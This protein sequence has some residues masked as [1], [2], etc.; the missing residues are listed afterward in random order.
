MDIEALKER[1]EAEVD[2]R[3]PELIDVSHRIHARPELLF[4]EHHAAA[5]LCDALEGAG[6][7]VERGICDLATA[8]SAR[9]GG[10]NGPTIAV[11]LEYD[12][13]PGIGHACGHNIIAAAGLGTG[14]AA[15]SVADEVGGRLLVLGTPAEEGGGGK[16]LMAD[17]GAFDHV[18]AAMMV[19]PAHF[20]L[21]E[22]SSLAISTHEITYRG[23]AAHAAAFPWEGRNAL[24]AAVLGYTAVAALR[25][26]IRPSERVHGVFTI[27]GDKP[28]IVPELAVAQWY[29][30]AATI[31]ALAPLEA[32]V[33]AALEA[34]AAAAGCTME[35]RSLAPTYADVRTNAPMAA[36]YTLNAARSGRTVLP[37]T[38]ETSV[39]A[40]TDMG[41]ISYRVPSI[42]PLIKVP[43]DDTLIHTAGFA[44]WAAAPEGDR[45]V[46]DG[47][48]A[49]ATTVLDL[50][51]RPECLAEAREA[52]DSGP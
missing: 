5:L 12:A 14:L 29:V 43:T 10:G 17:R 40:S 11:L 21:E 8:F 24:D 51:A 33:L 46:V 38:P 16:V 3:S 48:K 23:R 34:G 37:S 39:V 49:M 41:N 18:D 7:T 4:E 32:R 13:L 44:R 25:Q 30:R 1:V 45:A 19:H 9:A 15:A 22:M 36:L 26:H 31:D 6:L 20:D 27:G 35:H 52:F 50:W 42:H 47:A 28:N 2:R